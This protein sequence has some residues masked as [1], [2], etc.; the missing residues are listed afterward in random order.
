MGPGPPGSPRP[1]G[2]SRAEVKPEPRLGAGLAPALDGAGLRL[3][4]LPLHP[5]R[6]LE[7]EGRGPRAAEAG[8][9]RLRAGGRTRW[10]SGPVAQG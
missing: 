3:H 8:E 4:P 7:E 10:T 1:F 5:G 2:L 9:G 6:L